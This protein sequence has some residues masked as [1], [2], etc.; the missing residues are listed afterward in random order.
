MEPGRGQA[1]VYNAAFRQ[2]LCRRLESGIRMRSTIMIYC[3]GLGAVD[4]RGN[5]TNVPTVMIGGLPA[6]VSYA[7]AAIPANYPAGGAPTLLGV[8]SSN[9]GGL[10]Q[11]T[12]TVP[13]TATAGVASVVISSAGQSSQSGVTM[14]VGAGSGPTQPVSIATGGVLNAASFAKNA[15]GLGT[16]VA[17]GSIVA[18]FG[19]FPGATAA[20]APSI[21]YN[22]S[23]GGVTV[24]FNGALAPLQGVAPGGDFPF[25]THRAGAIRSAA[26]H[27]AGRGDRQRAS[28]ATG[29]CADRRSRSRHLHRSG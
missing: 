20:S 9:L 4:A 17:P 5:A 22:T 16:A 13:S 27:G 28:F 8:V 14:V 29:D 6:A 2:P 21:P 24:S 15:Q 12:A 11:I 26:R 1:L 18:I 10:Y 25:I 23:L 7:G 3:S 19:S